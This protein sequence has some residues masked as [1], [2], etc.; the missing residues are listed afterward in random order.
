MLLGKMC[1]DCWKEPDAVH[2][3]WI[4]SYDSLYAVL[5]Y[6]QRRNL[7]VAVLYQRFSHLV[8]A[9]A[10]TSLILHTVAAVFS[11]PF[12]EDDRSQHKYGLSAMTSGSFPSRRGRHSGSHR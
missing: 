1:R 10:F 2:M 9:P 3:C 5:R 6:I 12:H 7:S 4:H 11:M 8:L